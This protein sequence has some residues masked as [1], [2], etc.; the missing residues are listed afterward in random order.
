LPVF[1]FIAKRYFITKKKKNFINFI[2]NLSL[3]GVALG[4]M[5]LVVVLSVF[6]GLELLI[7][8]IYGSFDA[9]LKVSAVVGKSFEV[10]S[11]F[12]KKIKT[13]TYISIITEVIEDNALVKYEGKQA[14]VRMKGVSANFNQQYNLKK[15]IVEGKLALEEGS[16][17][18]AILGRGVQYKLG[19]NM[20]NRFSSL[21]FWYPKLGNKV[22]IN[23]EK[24][25]NIDLIVPGSVFMLEKQYDDHY[26]FVP[27]RFAANITEYDTKRTS[28][29]IRLS[30]K[31][32]INQV[33]SELEKLLG[34]KF[35]VET[36]EQQH[37]GML[38]ALK[39]ERLFMYLTFS[40]ILLIS[41]LNIFFSLTMLAIE[42]QD[43]MKILVSMGAT[44]SMI[45]NI[46]LT[47]GLL[48]ASV[49]ASI[50]IFLGFVI[51]LLQK[52]YGFVPM[53]N[54]TSLISSYP[55]E[56]KFMD[57]LITG[58]IIFAITMLISYQPAHKTSRISNFN[59]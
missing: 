58:I 37:V 57:F 45:R 31:A 7:K 12:T 1:F 18:T 17:P 2:T 19:I 11:L 52:M 51:C 54:A 59:F 55:V 27:L 29:E 44:Q 47:E 16:I 15:Y 5:A 46:F 35:K 40:F 23:P 48:I 28:L 36:S 53:G 24:S 3:V 39:I 13:V 26:I 30:D 43:D 20:Q 34:D 6:N 9:D 32:K 8:N 49:G 25:F 22:D 42:K 41:S 33:K 56:M 21:E 4:T 50:G 38:K 14:I 10:D